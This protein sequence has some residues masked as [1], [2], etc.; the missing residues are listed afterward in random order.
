M[1]QM[2]MV[3]WDKVLSLRSTCTWISE[4]FKK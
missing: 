4:K 3:L 2:R 1:H